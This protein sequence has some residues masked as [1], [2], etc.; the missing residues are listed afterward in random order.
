M[1]DEVWYEFDAFVTNVGVVYQPEQVVE[2][3]IQF[4]TSGEIKLLTKTDSEQ[5]L[6]Q[7]DI[8]R[9]VLGEAQTG[10]DEFDDFIIVEQSE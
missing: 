1:D 7:E 6:L 10:I 9:I 3:T 8:G 4:V 2:S 5:L